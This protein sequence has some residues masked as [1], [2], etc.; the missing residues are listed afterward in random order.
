MP[1]DNTSWFTPWI[2]SSASG[3]GVKVAFP[4]TWAVDKSTMIFFIKKRPAASGNESVS[5]HKPSKI[6]AKLV[7]VS[8]A[9]IRIFSRGK[10]S[11]KGSRNIACARVQRNARSYGS[12][13]LDPHG[14]TITMNPI[15]V[16]VTN[17]PSRQ[18][19]TIVHQTARAFN[20][21]CGSRRSCATLVY[22]NNAA[23]QMN[24]VPPQ[25]PQVL[26]CKIG[27]GITNEDVCSMGPHHRS[28]MPV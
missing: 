2:L 27:T 18:S 22:A 9:T 26:A 15:T 13:L 14:H 6:A 17:I 25:D 19:R 11:A 21:I 16:V 5:D 7:K 3:R 28:H 4:S 8:E 23:R 20:N 12:S 10:N 1:K 24:M